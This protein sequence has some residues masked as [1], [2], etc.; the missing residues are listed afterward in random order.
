MLPSVGIERPALGLDRVPVAPLLRAY[1]FVSHCLRLHP[2]LLAVPRRPPVVV[3]AE[4]H[5]HGGSQERPA[6]SPGSVESSS[7]E[8]DPAVD[9][10]HPRGSSLLPPS[11]RTCSSPSTSAS[12]RDEGFVAGGA[13]PLLRRRGRGGR[14]PLPRRPPLE[15]PEDA[16]QTPRRLKK[17]LVRQ[18][19]FRPN[20]AAGLG[21]DPDVP[22][23]TAQGRS[24]LVHTGTLAL[25]GVTFCAAGTTGT[26]VPMGRL[27]A[28][29]SLSAGRPCPGNSGSRRAGGQHGAATS[30]RASRTSRSGIPRG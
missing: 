21:E 13:L 6:V 29:P 7:A 19:G 1:T 28:W 10:Q 15:K 30:R 18:H 9:S 17:L 27:T 12:P 4:R 3:G 11:W 8:V 16:A 26:Q 25:T 2:R 5:G 20:G 22:T 23:V 14:P 24:P